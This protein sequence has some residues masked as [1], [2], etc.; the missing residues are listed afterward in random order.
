MS[1]N[2]VNGFRHPA[3]E[4]EYKPVPGHFPDDIGT[5]GQHAPYYEEIRPYEDFPE[6]IV[7]PTVWKAQDYQDSPEKWT[8]QLTEQEIKEISEAADRF[9]ASGLPLLNISK[10]SIYSISPNVV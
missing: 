1:T 2:V 7:G 9:K 10:V 5:S 3:T 4:E 6:E 8:H